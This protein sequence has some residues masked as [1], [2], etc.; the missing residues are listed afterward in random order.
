MMHRWLVVLVPFL[1]L[2]TAVAHH[3]DPLEV[4][5]VL[6]VGDIPTIYHPR[7]TQDAYIDVTET[8]IGLA[9]GGEA[10]AYPI[11]IM[12]WH[13][14]VN[15]T[16]DG[17]PVAITYCPL[18]GTGVVFSRLVE[19]NELTLGVSGKLYKSNLVLFDNETGSYWTQIDGEAILGPL[20]GKRLDWVPSHTVAWGDWVE[21]FPRSL[22]LLPPLPQCEGGRT[23]DSCR[24][25]TID[26]YRGYRDS[27]IVYDEFGGEYTDTILHPKA[28]VLG[29]VV[30]GVAMAYP[31]TVLETSLVVNDVLN[32]QPLVITYVNGS[33]QA[34]DS[35]DREFS[36]LPGPMMADESGGLWSRLHGESLS[37]ERLPLVEAGNSMWFAWVEFHP[38]TGVFALRPPSVLTFALRPTQALQ[39]KGDLLLQEVRFNNTAQVALTN[40]RMVVDLGV[41]LEF[42]R[43]QARALPMLLRSSPEAGKLLYEFGPVPPG[44]YS[45][46]IT[47]RVRDRDLPGVFFRSAVSIEYVDVDGRTVTA[48]KMGD[49]FRVGERPPFPTHLLLLAMVPLPLVAWWLYR[50]KGQ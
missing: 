41:A 10:R 20:H 40:L 28:P 50:R 30:G 32:R 42:V 26:P 36:P 49:T 37:G 16:V 27:T 15:D 11:K 19:G 13:E 43:D 34:F 23:G 5:K 29:I 12:N 2:P 46:L 14:V 47:A 31:L 4:L 25:Y 6:E 9:T 8:V 21:R 35:G 48:S 22:L 17:L 33:V 3:V 24:D 44:P 38:G 7:F 39:A 1:L 18:C 45:F